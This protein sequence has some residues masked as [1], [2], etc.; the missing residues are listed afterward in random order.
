MSKSEIVK[1]YELED[2]P[3]GKEEDE[4]LRTSQRARQ[5]EEDLEK[6][7]KEKDLKEDDDEE[8]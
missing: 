5:V 2:R 6:D 1:T 7:S 8:E 4:E 3:K